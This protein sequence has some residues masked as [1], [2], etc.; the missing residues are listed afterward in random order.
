MKKLPEVPQ[1]EITDKMVKTLYCYEKTLKPFFDNFNEKIKD[2]HSQEEMADSEKIKF[3]E[4]EYRKFKN[5]LNQYISKSVGAVINFDHN[6]IRR[7][8]VETMPRDLDFYSKNGNKIDMS[9]DNSLGDFLLKMN[10]E[11]RSNNTKI[12]RFLT[13]YSDFINFQNYKKREEE[14]V[15]YFK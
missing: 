9:E 10:E 4:E 7:G 5:N 2:I 14:A 1:I 15:D 3:I 11:I 13:I 12:K 8:D 6:K